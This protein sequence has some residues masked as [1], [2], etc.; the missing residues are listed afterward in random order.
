MNKALANYRKN[1]VSGMTQKELIVLL[2][3][4]ALRFLDQA[5]GHLEKKETNEFADKLE[6]VHRIVYHLYTT[7][8]FEKGGE[9]AE[10]LGSLYSFVISQLYILNSTKNSQLIEDI[11]AILNDLRDGWQNIGKGAEAS[12]TENA[13]SEQKQETVQENP[14][15]PQVNKA[16]S[17]QV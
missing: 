15:N 5:A 9:I 3:D 1:Q 10:K 17:V 6:R 16:V 4:G 14:Q 11:K 8:D 2:Y 7:L 13:N 12:P